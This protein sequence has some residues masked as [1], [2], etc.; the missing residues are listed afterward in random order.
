M[1]IDAHTHLFAEG[2]LPRWSSSFFYESLAQRAR[3]S[4][5]EA[6]EARLSALDPTGDKRIKGLDEIGI[7]KTMVCCIDWG[8]VEYM[9]DAAINI[10]EI[11]HAHSEAC[12]RHPDRMTWAVGI[13]P[14]RKNAIKI[15]DMGIKE[16]GAKA[17]K[18]YPPA[19]FYPNDRIVYPLY[20][21]CM[22]LGIP[23]DFH[24][25]PIGGPL[26]NKYSHPLHLDDVAVDFPG[27]TI[28]ATHTGHSSWQEMLAVARV[29]PNIVCNFAGWLPWVQSSQPVQFYRVWRHISDM[30]GPGRL[31][32]ASDWSGVEL[33]LPYVKQW[34][35]TFTQIPEMVKQAGVDFTK[36]EI[37]DFLSGTAIKVLH[38]L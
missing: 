38:L 36:Q 31:M 19:G 13:D 3:I 5:S 17:L 16:W 18:L 10:E 14:R 4:I 25:G 32:F 15:L 1:I 12:N 28:I 23:V 22:E 34:L 9:E 7:D 8:L 26:R 21:K 20:E 11:N 29:R 2:W 35:Q 6:K 24:T 30:L 33:E 27:L 37:D